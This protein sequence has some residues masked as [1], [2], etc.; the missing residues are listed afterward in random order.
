M[1]NKEMAET[2]NI[3]VKAVEANITRALTKLRENTKEYLPELV[4]LLIFNSQI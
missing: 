4:F 1:K 2:L 3:S